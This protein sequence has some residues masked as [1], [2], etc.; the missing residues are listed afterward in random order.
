LPFGVIAMAKDEPKPALIALPA[1]L[2]VV[3]I[4]V[5]PEPVVT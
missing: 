2:V 5:T 4:G 3:L 1:L